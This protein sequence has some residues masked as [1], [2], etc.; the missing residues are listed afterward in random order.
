VKSRWSH[1]GIL[2]AIRRPEHA[3]RPGTGGLLL[4]GSSING[5]GQIVGN[6]TLIGQTRALLLP[7]I[8][9]E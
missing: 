2:V 1:S 3:H 8:R 6:G 4:Q 9:E 5:S 7:P